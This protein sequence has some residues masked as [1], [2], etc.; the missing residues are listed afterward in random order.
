MA[1]QEHLDILAKG[2]E[3]WNQ[4]VVSNLGRAHIID[5]RDANLKGMDLQQICLVSA[6]LHGANLEGADLRSADLRSVSLSNAN[7]R[8]AK[9]SV[10]MMT[11]ASLDG[12]NLSNTE[13]FLT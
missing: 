5:L 11:H 12:A 13:L 9:L 8:G 6:H 10:A 4:W 2:V 3:A 7:L 1:N